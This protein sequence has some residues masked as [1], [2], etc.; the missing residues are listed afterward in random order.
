MTT[1]T[2]AATAADTILAIDLGEYKSVAC[3]YGRATAHAR[4]DTVR[5]GK[6]E[7][8]RLFA[9]HRPAVVVIEACA[10]SGWVADLCEQ[11]GLPCKVANTASEAWKFKHTKRKTDRDDALRLAQ[12]EAL[13]QLPTVALPPPAPRQWRSLIAY[14]QPL[15]GRRV[16]VP[17]RIPAPF[18]SPGPPAPRGA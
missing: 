13:G 6:D 18:L 7:L 2:T 9:R 3:A 1:T 15:A 17:T 14:R 5:T 11:L 4:F 8:A 16:A 10:L 12:L